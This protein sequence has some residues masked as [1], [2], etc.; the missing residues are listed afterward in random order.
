MKDIKARI[1]I[2]RQFGSGGRAIGR[3]IADAL[4]IPYYDKS[5]LSEAAAHA[6]INPELF[7]RNDEKAPSFFSGLMSYN[8]GYSAVSLFGA[9]SSISDD[10]IYRAQTEV[11]RSIAD[12]GP[13]VIVGRSADYALRRRDDLVSIFLHAPIEHRVSRILAR[14]DAPTA[15]HARILAEK[16]DKLRASYYNFYTDKHWGRADSYDLTLD[17]SLMPPADI[18]ELVARYIDLRFKQ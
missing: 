14:G 13:C 3:A 4:G 8:M 10:A 7:E 15:E 9:S 5:L 11:I 17:S 12:R 2:G 18:V 6:G 1:T 16:T